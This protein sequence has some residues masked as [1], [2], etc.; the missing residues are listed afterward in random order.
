[1][2]D[3]ENFGDL[4]HDQQQADDLLFSITADA[5]LEEIHNRYKEKPKSLVISK[6]TRNQI[7]LN[8]IQYVTRGQL[9]LAQTLDYL[10]AIVTYI[11]TEGCIDDE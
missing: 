9:T 6:K 3:N 7:V 4:L 1:M 10:C 2:T 5:I 11:A 8:S